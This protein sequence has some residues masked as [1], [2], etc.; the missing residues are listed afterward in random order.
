VALFLQPEV[1][2]DFRRT[3]FPQLT[4]F[5]PAENTIPRRMLYPQNELNNNPDKVPQNITIF[6]RVWWDRE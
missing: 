3:G 1:W 4:P 5:N 2:S 6:S